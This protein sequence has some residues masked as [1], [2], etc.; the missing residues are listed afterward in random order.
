M[1]FYLL[2]HGEEGFVLTKFSPFFTK[3]LGVFSDFLRRF[4]ENLRRFSGNLRRFC[5]H[6]RCFVFLLAYSF[7]TICVQ[8]SCIMLHRLAGEKG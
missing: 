4:S 6:L 2:M 8:L 5:C 3:N 1:L 7:R